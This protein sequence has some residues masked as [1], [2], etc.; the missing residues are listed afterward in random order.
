MSK[1]KYDSA[2]S[3]DAVLDA[4][5]RSLTS[6]DYF[7]EPQGPLEAYATEGGKPGG[8]KAVSQKLQVK[9]EVDPR[10]GHVKLKQ[11]NNGAAYAGAGNPFFTVRL[12]MKF[13]QI[14]KVVKN[15]LASVSR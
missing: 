7:W 12:N 8:P 9:V 4:V 5:R 15:D 2:A 1:I 3:P 14:V 13:S 6:R 10:K 11:Q